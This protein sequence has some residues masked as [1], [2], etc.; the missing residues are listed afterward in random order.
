M[1][2]LAGMVGLELKV[3]EAVRAEVSKEKYSANHTHTHTPPHTP[4]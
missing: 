3:D 2:N 1:L 4:N